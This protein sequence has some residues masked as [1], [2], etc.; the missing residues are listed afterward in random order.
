MG[1]KC[2]CIYPPLPHK[3][4]KYISFRERS[5]IDRNLIRNKL[6]N[7]SKPLLTKIK[8]QSRPSQSIQYQIFA[9]FNLLGEQSDQWFRIQKLL[10]NYEQTVIQLTQLNVNEL[11]KKQIDR[12]QYWLDEYDKLNKDN[13]ITVF[14]DVARGILSKIVEVEEEKHQMLMRELK[15]A[16]IK[17]YN[18]ESEVDEVAIL[19]V[20]QETQPDQPTVQKQN[21]QSL[22]IGTSEKV[23]Q[24]VLESPMRSNKNNLSMNHPHNSSICNIRRFLEN[25][26]PKSPLNLS[27]C[28]SQEKSF[29]DFNKNSTQ[30]K[31]Q[32]CSTIIG[33]GVYN[34]IISLKKELEMIQR[35]IS[36]LEFKNKKDEFLL[37]RQNLKNHFQQSNEQ[38]RQ[39]L[40]NIRAQTQND[41]SFTD[42]QRKEKLKIERNHSAFRKELIGSKSPRNEKYIKYV[43][44]YSKKYI[45]ILDRISQQEQELRSV[46]SQIK[47]AEKKRT[48]EENRSKKIL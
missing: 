1:P 8:Y 35:D 5:P 16:C 32:K 6:T 44:K 17:K 29:G 18:D 2:P 42:N 4:L 9:L 25:S 33:G 38:I 22:E 20:T 48:I 21:D 37:N 27:F 47:L 13:Q 39:E 34:D 31:Q 26:S 40:L 43:E 14:A 12:C 24:N 46:Q 19:Q 28:K 45:P 30:K 36:R 41:E 3:T 15:D 23:N 7:I 11:N 10:N